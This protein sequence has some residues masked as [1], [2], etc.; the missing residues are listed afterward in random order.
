[1]FCVIRNGR[2]VRNEGLEGGFQI[3]LNLYYM[4]FAFSFWLVNRSMMIVFWCERS[5][6]ESIYIYIGYIYVYVIVC[7]YNIYLKIVMI[8]LYLCITWVV[9]WELS[10]FGYVV[11]DVS[12]RAC[13]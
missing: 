12:I 7:S 5:L 1:M 8:N 9:Y 10:V 11:Y 6:V 3:E 13:A 2:V 4:C